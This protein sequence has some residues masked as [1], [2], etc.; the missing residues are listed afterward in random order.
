MT[1]SFLPAFTC[2]RIGVRLSSD[3]VK[4][5]LIGCSCVIT[6]IP[7]VSPAVT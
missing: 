1:D 3:V 4:I 2:L 5:T 7:F 6:T